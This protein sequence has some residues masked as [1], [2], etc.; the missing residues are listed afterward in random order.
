[1]IAE[2]VNKGYRINDKRMAFVTALCLLGTV[3]N[4]EEFWIYL[5]ERNVCISITSVYNIL[6]ILVREDLII[7]NRFENGCNYVVVYAD[8]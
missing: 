4:P 5:K 8:N 3:S 2:L 1:M 7:K 6:R